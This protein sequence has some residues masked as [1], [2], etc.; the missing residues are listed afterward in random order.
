M[1]I[2]CTVTINWIIK[3]GLKACV[4]P[5]VS[6]FLS[7]AGVLCVCLIREVQQTACRVFIFMLSH[8]KPSTEVPVFPIFAGLRPTQI[9]WLDN[10]TLTCCLWFFISQP[11][12]RSIFSKTLKDQDISYNFLTG[13]I[14]EKKR[15]E[16]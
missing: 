11:H 9:S 2:K 12:K 14:R 4:C 5:S 3:V 1:P 15:K 16:K 7:L 10:F 8:T 6:L 13:Q